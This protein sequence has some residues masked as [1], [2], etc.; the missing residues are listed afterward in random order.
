MPASFIPASKFPVIQ[1]AVLNACDA[2]DGVK[3]GVLEDP[4]RCKF[5]PGVIL[6]KGADGPELPDGRASGKRAQDIQSGH[7][8][9]HEGSRCSQGLNRAAK[10][11]G[12]SPRVSVRLS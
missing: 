12:D 3:D 6:C 1:K 2:N 10:K 11:A 9:T 7:K 8:S 4:T 5:D